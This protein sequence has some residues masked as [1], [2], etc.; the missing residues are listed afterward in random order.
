MKAF[1]DSPVM[2]MLLPGQRYLLKWEGEV[3]NQM[4]VLFESLPFSKKASR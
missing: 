4:Q 1:T 3:P 2:V